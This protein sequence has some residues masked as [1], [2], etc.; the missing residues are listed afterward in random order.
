[1]PV[2]LYRVFCWVFAI[3]LV[4]MLLRDQRS[5]ERVRHQLQACQFV[6]KLETDYAQAQSSCDEALEQ[7]RDLFSQ[8]EE[9]CRCR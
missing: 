4:L 2:W 5:E 3:I 8:C 7:S 1:M 9:R 6:S